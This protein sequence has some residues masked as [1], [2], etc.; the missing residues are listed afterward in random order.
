MDQKAMFRIASGLYILS[1]RD[2]NGHN[3]ACVINTVVQV[4]ETPL[5]IVVAVNKN[6]DT[7]DTVIRA[8]KF[9]LSILDETTK[10]DTIRHF[11]F[12]SSRDVDK[13]AHAPVATAIHHDLPRLTQSAN[14]VLECHIVE[15]TDLGSHSL[16]LADVE[17]AEVLNA[18]GTLTYD[19]YQKRVKPR[20]QAP[21]SNKTVWRCEICGFEIE[22]DELPDDYVCPLCLHGRDAFVKIEAVPQKEAPKAAA[23]EITFVSGTTSDALKGTRTEANLMA[24]FSGESQARNKYTYYAAKAKEEGY[25]QIAAIFLETAHNESE[26]AKLW[27]KCLHNDIIPNTENNLLDAAN[28]ENY[29]WTDMYAGFARDAREEGFERI[30]LLF[31]MV[32]AIEK[33]H[34]ER[35][36]RLLSNVEN[37]LVFSKDGDAIWECRNC[38]HIVIGKKAPEACAVCGY[39]QAYFQ[40]KVEID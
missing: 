25:E 6:N 28:G 21:K 3:A 27:F 26:H 33:H 24:A 22:A 16:I 20:P 2:Q 40:L 17:G 7:H 1:A 34:E 19:D 12:Q 8:G 23:D 13:F 5:R 15:A 10:F 11:G 31:E 32:G 39:A 37:Q 36:R 30:A 18:Y 29:E 4:T 14:A 9:A 35:Y 38:G